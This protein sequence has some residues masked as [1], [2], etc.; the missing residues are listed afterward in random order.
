MVLPDFSSTES[1]TSLKELHTHSASVQDRFL[2]FVFDAVLSFPFFYLVLSP[3]IREIYKG[4]IFNVSPGES[5]LLFALAAFEVICIGILYQSLCWWQF[6]ATA[7]QKILK[8][9]VRSTTPEPLSFPRALM[10]ACMWWAELFFFALPILEVI[11]H[12][13]RACLHDRVAETWV[14]TD[15]KSAFD[16]PAEVERSFVTAIYKGAAVF[17]SFWILVCGWYFFK[18]VKEYKLTESRLEKDDK[19][20]EAVSDRL[21]SDQVFHIKSRM[22]RALALYAAGRIDEECLKKEAQFSIWKKENVEAYLAFSFVFKSELKKSNS[23]LEKVCKMQPESQAC[24]VAKLMRDGG[25]WKQT[26]A[27]DISYKKLWALPFLI[28]QTHYDLAEEIM[29]SM[30]DDEMLAPYLVSKRISIE[31]EKNDFAKARGLYQGAQAFLNTDDQF[32]VLASLCNGIR[33][34][35]CK[36]E[37]EVSCQWL[38]T[39]AEQ[40]IDPTNMEKAAALL[41]KP[42]ACSGERMPASEVDEEISVLNGET[43]ASAEAL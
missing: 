8:I 19:L 40:T 17:F 28:R 15:K 16:F 6:G 32:D 38:K 9:E 22:E 36:E 11:A 5:M 33:T 1:N 7:G 25:E 41:E 4:A 14:S 37:P 23:Y 3:L 30:Q 18:H 20:C 10:R 26:K 24:D 12:Y 27:D 29:T 34:Q 2:A 13:R 21:G 39:V 43:E 31:I 35:E 42:N